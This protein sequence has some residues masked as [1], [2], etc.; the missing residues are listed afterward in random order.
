M[1]KFCF[2]ILHYQAID[3]T[4]ECVKSIIENVSYPNYS[5]VIV[6]NKSPNKSGQELKS[7]YQNNDKVTVLLNEENNG[8]AKGN[9][10]GYEYAKEKL[11]ADFIACINNDTIIEDKWFIDKIIDL[12]KSEEFHIM[13]PDIIALDGKHQNPMRMKPLTL[14]DV[15][16][17][18]KNAN[19]K[20]DIKILKTRLLKF[21]LIRKLVRLV[22]RPLIPDQNH[23]EQHEDVVLH[24]AAIVY[25]PLYIKNETYAFYPET[26]M[27]AEEHILYH[28]C[29]SKGYKI[30]YSPVTNILHKED[31]S[32]NSVTKTDVNKIKFVFKHER[33][34]YLILKDILEKLNDT[35][36]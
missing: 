26:F 24:G 11:S 23:L 8:F 9:N 16:N 30:I 4:K 22:K 10:L 12:Y 28:L 34:S 35:K 13:G 29:K 2:V 17:Y 31:A 14:E 6:D 15:N 27:F 33:N 19:K 20:R 32:T 1:Y 25:S 3:E 36:R 5:I 18:L 7:Y 21:S